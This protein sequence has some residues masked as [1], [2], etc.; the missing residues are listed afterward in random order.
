M[1]TSIWRRVHIYLQHLYIK[2]KKNESKC[3]DIKTQKAQE[4]DWD[5]TLAAKLK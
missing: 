3:R 5:G 4:Q 1:D 2:K